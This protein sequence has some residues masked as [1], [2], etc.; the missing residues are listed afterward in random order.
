MKTLMRI[1][2]AFLF[3]AL[4]VLILPA[5]VN[6]A[7]DADSLS[8]TSPQ[9]NGCCEVGSNCAQTSK[10]NCDDLGGDYYAGKS[11]KQPCGLKMGCCQ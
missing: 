11:C 2:A 7:L 1:N 5:S 10:N 9:G 6:G 3:S 4:A 8:P